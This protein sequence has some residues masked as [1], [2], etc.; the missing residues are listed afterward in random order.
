MTSGYH[1]F[2]VEDDPW[3]GEILQYHLS[4]NPDYKVTKFMNGRDCIREL[5]QKPDL[6]TMDYSLPDM[7]G[8]EL[9]KQ[10]QQVNPNIPVVIISAQEDV[11]TAIELYKKGIADYL[12]KDD[13]TKDLLWNAV[14]RIRENQ[15]LKKEVEI[16]REEL[17]HKYEFGKIIIGSSAPIKK[18]F[19]L[20]E[21]AART[22]INVSVTGE[23]GTGKELVAKAIHYHS[24]R[25]KKPFVALN[26][27]AIPAELLESELFGH[28]KGAFTGALARK[29]GKFEEANGGTLFLDEIGEMDVNLQSK[30]LRVLQ[31]RELTRVGGTDKIKLDI[32]L[33][34]ATHKNLAEQ[35]KQGKF[36]EDFY[37]RIMGLPIELPPLR[38]RGNDLLLLAKFFLDEFCRENKLPAKQFS[39]KAKERLL[40]YDFPGNVREL[41]SMVDLAAVMADGDEIQEDDIRFSAPQSEE[42]IFAKEKTLKEYTNQI[43]QHFLNKYNHSV[44]KVADKL[45][46]GK[47]TIYKMIQEK[48]IEG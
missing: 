45:D 14:N 4:L 42:D 9:L 13:H 28:E 39:T 11:T 40:K 5:H 10:V 8:A 47:S 1:I 35:V 44:L 23:T 38:E 2:I 48:E 41:K 3:Y 34:V 7:N 24:D 17:G 32:R 46:V 18:I 22:N 19:T 43:V 12:V 29:N 27:A 36:R 16:L 6:I 26:M 30:L 37:Y 21:K 20:M 31:E 15:A 33:I 25:K